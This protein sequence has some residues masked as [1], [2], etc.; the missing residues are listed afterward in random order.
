MKIKTQITEL[1]RV[2]DLK[3]NAKGLIKQGATSS[4]INIYANQIW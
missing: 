3:I 1:R 4:V 2:A